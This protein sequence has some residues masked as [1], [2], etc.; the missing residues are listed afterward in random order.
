MSIGEYVA[1][2]QELG[3]LRISILVTITAV[4]GYVM[5]DGDVSGKIF[6]P[7]LGTFFLALSAS[8][9]NHYQ[10]RN[11]DAMMPRTKDRPLPAGKVTEQQVLAFVVFTG[12]NGMV[13]LLLGGG[14]VSALL[15]LAALGWYNGIYTPLKQKSA[16]AII[17]GSLIGAIPPVIGWTAGGGSVTSPVIL[18][19]AFF[20]FIWQIPHFW[21]L[22]LKYG[23]QYKLAGMPTLTSLFSKEQLSRITFSWILA[24]AMVCVSLPLFGVTTNWLV[25]GCLWV[26]S[27]WLVKRSWPI[28]KDPTN[29]KVIGQTF[30]T[31]NIYVFVIM[32]VFSLERVIFGPPQLPGI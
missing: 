27:G 13:I 11:I 24:T 14:W 15:G 4:A 7:M 31:I 20:L 18:A 6:I 2:F 3:K 12:F 23:P 26:S 16:F 25:K 19:I 30:L 22:L 9:L 8:A 29:D 28:V 1:A 17:P 5:V 21:L 32:L 10:E